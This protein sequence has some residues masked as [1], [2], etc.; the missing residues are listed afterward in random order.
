MVI[1]LGDELAGRQVETGVEV[2]ELLEGYGDRLEREGCEE[3]FSEMVSATVR[4]LTP[5]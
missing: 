3:I 1:A 2:R 4:S 5:L